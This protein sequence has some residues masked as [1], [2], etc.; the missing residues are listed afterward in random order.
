MAGAV[1]L[2]V[3]RPQDLVSLDDVGDR[4]AQCRHVETAGEADRERDV[5]DRRRRVESVEEPHPLLCERQRDDGAAVLRL[6]REAPGLTGVR[7]EAG[8]EG[9]DSGDSNR[10]RTGM[11]VSTTA[12]SRATACVA[13]R[14]LPPSSKKSSSRPTR[15]TPSRSANAAATVSSSGFDGA[16]NS[17]ASNTGSGNAFRSSL[18]FPVRGDFVEGHHHGGNHVGRQ[19]PAHEFLECVLVDGRSG[20]GKHI[21]HQ[22][23]HPRSWTSARWSRR[24]RRSRERRAPRRSHRVRCGNRGP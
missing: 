16:R 20:R 8:G 15:S 22:C 19:R 23:R 12:P 18:P 24:T 21:R 5:V 4:G 17:R 11:R 10:S 14:E 9:F 3:H 13:I 1:E 2:R 6:E 7:G